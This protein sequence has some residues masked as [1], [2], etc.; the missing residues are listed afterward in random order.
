MTERQA[1]A[2]V[3]QRLRELLGTPLQKKEDKT[4]RGEFDLVVTAGTHTY[5]IEWKGTAGYAAVTNGAQQVRRYAAEAHAIPILAVPFMSEESKR[6]AEKQ[7]VSW[8]DLSGNASITAPGV[9]IV[10]E[11]RKN[12]FKRPG[13][14]MNLFA[15]KS[16]RITRWLLIN[17]KRA[18]GLRELA[19]A[20]G[21]EPGYASRIVSKLRDAELVYLDKNKIRVRSPEA[22]LDAW[23][24]SEDFSRHDITR[25][26][27]AARSGE[28]ALREIAHSLKKHSFEY[29]ATGLAATWMYRRFAAFR[30][31]TLYVHEPVPQ[32]ILDDLGIRHEPT[33]PN[34]W[35]AVPRDEGV[36]QGAGTEEG[37]TCVHPIQA[38]VDLKA[39]PERSDEAAEDLRSHLELSS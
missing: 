3:Y 39:H 9:R 25:G 31:V 26:H 36:F 12:A 13:R 23:R 14:R 37:V 21:M 7:H 1:L 32:E 24:A 15:P 28:S 10:I 2:R 20:T 17:P 22:L 35:L 4:S 29:A 38:Y 18:F 8:L 6:A 19:A 30:L 5:V 34:V 11:G 27:I 33:A 16:S